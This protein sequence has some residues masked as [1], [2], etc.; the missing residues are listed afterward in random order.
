MPGF[1]GA[2]LLTIGL[3]IR[4]GLD[5]AATSGSSTDALAAKQMQLKALDLADRAACAAWTR[6]LP[7][8]ARP[9]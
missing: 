7:C 8:R 3:A 2:G 1:G 5:W 4:L 6:R 9:D